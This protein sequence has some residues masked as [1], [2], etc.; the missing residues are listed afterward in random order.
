M[1]G[2]TLR[3]TARTGFG[4]LILSALFVAPALA[5][6]AVV[7]G[8]VNSADRNEPISGVNVLIPELNISVLTTDRGAYVITVPAARIPTGPVTVTA[9]AIGFKSMSRTVTV[10]P[11]EQTADFS[12]ATDINR[13]EEVIVTGTLEGVER[14]KVPFAVGRLSAEDLPVPAIDPVRALAGKVAGLR[15]GSTTGFPGIRPEILL[16]GP[17]S[18]NGTGRSQEPLFIVDG[19]ILHVGSYQELGGLDIESVE[20]VKGAAGSS[21][22]GTQAANGVITI[23]TKRG[24]T[25]DGV[26]F[27]ARSEIGFQQFA[28]YWDAPINTP[29]QLDETGKRF[30]VIAA[31]GNQSCA[32]TVDLMTEMYRI[33]NV[34]SDTTRTP[35]PIWYNTFAT[36]DAA[37]YNVF[38]AN[39]YPGR[40]FNHMA[41]ISDYR[42][43]ML[44]S[45][46]ATGKIGTVGFYVSGQYTQDPGVIKGLNGSDQRRAR[47]N[48]DW[49]ARSDL[50]ISAST[51]F[52][53]YYRDSRTGGV[54]GVLQ[55]GAMPGFD[56]LAR[57]TLGRLLVGR[58]SSGWRPTGNGSAAVLYDTENFISDRTSNRFL[59]SISAKYFPASWIT[60]EG[61]FGYDN[62]TREDF[63]VVKKGYR[64]FTIS[65]ANNNGQMT[66][67]DSFDEAYNV[68]LS[69]TLRKKLTN[70][71]N[72][73]L[74]VAGGY[75]HEIIQNN[76]G[77]GQI[78]LVKDIFRLNNTSTNFSN[79]NDFARIKNASGS[80]AVNL[81]YKDRYIIDAS[82]RYDGSSL[83]GPGHR[84]A[85]F[86]RIAAVWRVDQESFWK[87]PFMQEF[88]LRAS[89]GTAG[90]TPRF[91]A[92]Y[93]VYNV[94]VTGITTGQAGNAALRPE[95]TT[96]YEFGTD[97]TLFNRLGMEVTYAHARTKDQ[98]LPVNVPASVGYSSQWQNAGTLLNK[99]W[100]IAAT[101]PI[102][103]N[104]N[105]YW[106][107]RATFDRTR[108]YIDELFVPDF[109]YNGGTGQGTGSFFYMT[110]DKRASCRPGEEGHLPGEAGYSAGEARPNC[111]GNALNRFGNIYGRAFYKSC[112]ELH[113]SIRDRCGEGLDFQVND[114]GFVVWVGA[115]NSWRDGITKNLWA[116][117]LRAADSPWNYTL[118]WGMPIVDRPL[119]GQPGEGTGIQQII[120]NT[121]PDYRF[122]VSNDFQFKKF[123][124]YGLLEA[125]VGHYVNNQTKAWGL[126]DLS[127]AGFDQAAKTVEDA[128]PLGYTWRAGGAEGAGVGGFYDQLGPNN[129]NVEKA[130]YAKLRE[131][132]VTYRVGSIGGVGDW[133][134]GLIGRNLFTITGY[135]GVD[136]EV[137][138]GGFDGSGCGGAG[139]GNLNSGI[140]NQSD[141]FSLPTLRTLTFS[142]STRF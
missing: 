47:L 86:N 84:W 16:R 129:F 23:T 99:T 68:G 55:R 89:R 70:D 58:G 38:Q 60:I 137:G 50:R 65:T 82:F 114:E 3:R 21:L 81:D 91:S 62:R 69:A 71:L 135:S 100:E 51:M 49:N 17:T 72:A 105:F 59:G 46:D 113:T 111:T 133:T 37:L 52:D 18:I 64:T 9:R 42:P 43:T 40:Y 33:N 138:C 36:G 4:A 124:I 116:T 61:V 56:M 90:S 83:F 39:I 96:E 126:L 97:F 110:A 121:L 101:L 25:T 103:N 130:S 53:N 98:I 109:L 41:Q 24:G 119:A 22:Y 14:Q 20:V 73:K 67:D 19:V 107:A 13:L 11:G 31:A 28:S 15:I 106:Q 87:V 6:N 77:R 80:A 48:L 57:D 104:R 128:K 12:L 108:T 63:A 120:G 44:Q 142:V 30:C 117:R 26:K 54:F 92:Q 1:M 127:Y 78:F 45:V 112:S 118:W 66:V 35:L 75:D 8:T 85:P 102:I 140:L 2:F 122:T 94:G 141:A 134:F 7:R 76:V 5:Q 27:N 132:S 125:T 32:R 10:R 74:R 131:L 34:N 123:T 93:E 95:T 79:G 115:G 88:R 139:G 136:P 29:N